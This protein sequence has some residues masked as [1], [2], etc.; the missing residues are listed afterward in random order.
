MLEYG[1]AQEFQING[2]LSISV[3]GSNL[4]QKNS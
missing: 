3:T 4:L 2:L 1:G